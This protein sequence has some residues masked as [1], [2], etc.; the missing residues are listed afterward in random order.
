MGLVAPIQRRWHASGR[1][2]SGRAWL[3]VG[4][5]RTRRARK[6]PKTG[7]ANAM[8]PRC[9][10]YRSP[11]LM[12]ASRTLDSSWTVLPSVRATVPVVDEPPRSA[13][14]AIYSICRSGIARH[15]G[16]S[17]RCARPPWARASP[18]LASGTVI[19]Q[20]PGTGAGTG[21]VGAVIHPHDP[22]CSHIRSYF[23]DCMINTYLDLV[24]IQRSSRL[25]S[26]HE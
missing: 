12:S 13:R 18:A 10:L 22:L 11:S 4:L 19:K 16:P 23:S 24:V 14:A 26:R 21:A 8:W 9:K 25:L 6:A 17:V 2:R 7:T 1:S 20:R 5:V 15:R 3:L